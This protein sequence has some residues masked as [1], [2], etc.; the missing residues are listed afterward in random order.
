MVTPGTQWE[1][2]HG[3]DWIHIRRRQI[4]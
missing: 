3:R 4:R 2:L 1:T